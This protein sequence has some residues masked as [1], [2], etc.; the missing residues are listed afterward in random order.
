MGRGR[1]T[2]DIFEEIARI[3]RERTE[4]ALATVVGGEKG[5]PGKM[6]FRMRVYPDG[7]ISGTVGGGLVE[8]K[9]RDEALRCL[10]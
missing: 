2:L 1:V 9:V 7:W 8:A 5:T 3:R 4:A 10:R 6:G